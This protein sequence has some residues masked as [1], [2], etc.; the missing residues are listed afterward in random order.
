[1]GGD[2]GA[3]ACQRDLKGQLALELAGESLGVSLESLALSP[4]LGLQAFGATSML[5]FTEVTFVRTC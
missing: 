3:E 1:M 2:D 4:V 5:A